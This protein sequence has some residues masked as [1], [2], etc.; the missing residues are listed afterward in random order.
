MIMGVPLKFAEEYPAQK[1]TKYVELQEWK[2]KL[3]QIGQFAVNLS[4]QEIGDKCDKIS[5]TRLYTM[6]ASTQ[7]KK[8]E[9]PENMPEEIKEFYEG[10]GK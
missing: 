5:I 1:P 4:I 3:N 2:E 6:R 8:M 7:V 9:W 10:S